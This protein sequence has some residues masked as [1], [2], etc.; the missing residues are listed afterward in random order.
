LRD[1]GAASLKVEGRMKSPEYVHAV[2]RLYR[3]ALDALDPQG[4]SG[5][6]TGSAGAAD[7]PG[8]NRGGKAETAARIEELRKDAHIAFSRSPSRAYFLGPRAESLIDSGYPGHR[9]IPA[10]KISGYR[11]PGPRA[12]VELSEPVG[13]RDGLSAFP[14]PRQGSGDRLIEPLAFSVQGLSDGRTGRELGLARAGSLVELELPSRLPAGTEL[15]KISSRS[16]DRRLPSPEEYQPLLRSLP[17]RLSLRQE[18]EGGRLVLDLDSPRLSLADSELLPLARAKVGGG[19]RRVAEL[20]AESGDA[21]FRLELSLDDATRLELPDGEAPLADLFIPPSLLKKAKNRIYAEL[22]SRLALLDEER[23]GK[24]AASLPVEME[25]TPVSMAGIPRPPR[26]EIVFNYDGLPAGMPFATPGLLASGAEL[27]R[28][29]AWSWLP[30][31]PLVGDWKGYEKAVLDR[32]SSELAAG[33]RLMVGVDALHHIPLAEKLCGLEPEAE[34]LSFF[35]DI[36]LYAASRR[37][38][39]AWRAFL[40]RLA[41]VYPYLE[42][43]ALKAARPSSSGGEFSDGPVGAAIGD[44]F[45]PPLFISRACFKRHHLSGGNCPQDCNRKHLE[46]L[47]DRERRYTLVVDDCVTMLFRAQ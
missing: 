23:A 2:A 15:Y 26:R 14:E 13:L 40:P 28:A 10:G 44:G 46:L 6:A 20:F 18:G 35:G 7:V 5:A 34:H 32:A 4:A 37:A 17:A 45:E 3:T 43:E 27:P 8:R 22:G 21:D 25:K 12:L 36:H 30:L 29:G 24:A 38:E 39:A 42:E 1:A 16:L 9:G 31:A 19:F 47:S 11:G 41:F 33:R